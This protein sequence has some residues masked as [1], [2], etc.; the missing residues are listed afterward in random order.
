VRALLTRRRVADRYGRKASCYLARLWLV[1]VAHASHTE[2]STRLNCKGCAL[3]NT[4]KTPAVWV[5][6]VIKLA[7]ERTVVEL[8]LT[9]LGPRQ[10]LQRHGYRCS[11]VR[12][13][14][15]EEPEADGA[16]L[17]ARST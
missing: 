4:A 12:P 1:V 5:R 3:L 8:I 17:P 9:T 13:L 10:T 7:H 14:L 6:P 11:P 16:E 2:E 15:H